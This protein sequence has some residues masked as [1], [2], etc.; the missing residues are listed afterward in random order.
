[1][2]SFIDI[3]PHPQD[4]N[5][6]AYSWFHSHCRRYFMLVRYYPTGSIQEAVQ[7]K[8]YF[9]Y[10]NHIGS[11]R[12]DG[13]DLGRWHDFSPGMTSSAV[14]CSD[15]L[16]RP[17]ACYPKRGKQWERRKWFSKM[18]PL[19]TWYHC[20]DGDY[21]EKGRKVGPEVM[22]I[23]EHGNYSK[24]RVTWW[25]DCSQ[26]MGSRRGVRGKLGRNFD[27]WYLVK[28]LKIWDI[29]SQLLQIVKMPYIR[30]SKVKSL[31]EKST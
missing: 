7:R 2:D 23:P 25:H 3:A 27:F 9:R 26:R 14:A 30:G 21:Q 4:E 31:V 22:E 13:T 17:S 8:K 12:T 18:A 24:G 28:F 1:M 19:K 15:H 16:I 10:R 6:C 5:R 29:L 11:E 20:Y